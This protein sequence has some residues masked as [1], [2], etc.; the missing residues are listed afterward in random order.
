MIRFL[1]A[2]IA[3]SPHI[4]HAADPAETIDFLN[5]GFGDR[6]G[7][8]ANSVALNPALLTASLGTP[9]SQQLT[10]AGGS[11]SSYT[12]SI[13]SGGLPHGLTL[14]AS[15]LL[16]GT[17][18]SGGT[19]TFKVM[20]TDTTISGLIGERTYTMAIASSPQPYPSGLVSWWRAEGNTND[21][22]G[23][24]HATL[25]GSV[26]YAPGLVGQAF[27]FNGT[28]GYVALPDNLFPVPAT[29]STTQSPFSFEVWFKLAP[30]GGGV[31]LS[32]QVNS[33]YGTGGGYVPAIYIDTTGRL[34]VSMFWRNSTNTLGG[35]GPSFTESS[36]FHH[37][38]VTFN[39]TH[40]KIF[41][42]GVDTVP[43]PGVPFTQIAYTATYRYSLGTGNTA[44]GW[45][46]NNGGYFNFNGLIDEPSVYN[47]A[48]TL[49]EAQALFLAG[50]EGKSESQSLVVTSTSDVSDAK[51][52]QITLRE[53]F[54]YAATLSGTQT[55]TFS[56]ALAGQT[57]TLTSVS[58]NTFGPSAFAVSGSLI[59]DGGTGGITI[60]QNNPTSPTG[61][62][63]LFYVKNT[64]NLTLRN[65][66]LSGGL[67]RG[68]SGGAGGGA[69]GLGGAIVNAG[70][71]NISQSTLLGNEAR[72]GGNNLGFLLGGAGLGQNSS[73][74]G[75]GGPNGGTF[76][77]GGSGGFGGGAYSG[78]RTA[79]A[80]GFGGG[81]SFSQEA[82]AGRGGFG[83]GGGSS[84]SST[85]G[86]GGYGASGGDYYGGCGAGMGGAI[87]NYGGNVTLTNSTLVGN[88]AIG[89]SSLLFI[90]SGAAGGSAFGGGC[91]NL[92]GTVT[93]L[94][95]TAAN[96]IIRGGTGTSSG[97]QIGGAIYSLG[98]SDI[99]TQSGPAMSANAAN[100]VIQNSILSGSTNGVTT[101]PCSNFSQVA[102]GTGTV[103]SSGTH[104]CIQ[105]DGSTGISTFSGSSIHV[106]PLLAPLGNNGGPTQTFA[107]TL[108]SPAINAGNNAAATGVTTDQ[109][110]GSFARSVDDTVDIGA[111]ELVEPAS[112]VVTRADDVS[113]ANDFQTS[114]RE[115]ITYATTLSGT[116]TITFSNA[117]ADGA[118]NFHDGTARSITLTGSLLTVSTALNI[119]G[120]GANFLTLQ[121]T[122]GSTRVLNFSEFLPRTLTGLTISSP[123]LT[124]G[125]IS[126]TNGNLTLNQC[127]IT[128]NGIE[129]AS[130]GAG[131]SARG[132][133]LTLNGCTLT[134][135]SALRGGGVWAFSCDVT[136][137][138]CT[139]SGNTATSPTSGGGGLYIDQSTF[140]LN[141]CSL[142]GN[143]ASFN[144]GGIHIFG[145]SS[146]GTFTNCTLSG[147][148]ATI[149]G[150]GI[151]EV[152]GANITLN[153]C[154]LNGNR[155]TTGTG[156]GLNISA[157]ATTLRQ[158][159]IS[160]NAANSN[161]GGA[162]FT[163]SS[164]VNLSQCTIS[165]NTTTN[166][167]GGGIGVAGGTNFSISNCILGNSNGY[168]LSF[169]ASSP[170]YSGINL[171]EDG[172][173]NG[174]GII[175][176]DPLLGPL[177]NN[178]GLTQTHALLA[179]SPA[180][181]AGINTA[182][183][184]LT[185]DQ[186]GI[187]FPRILNTTVDL[188]AIE[189]PAPSPLV[190][191][192]NLH[193]L[194][195]NGSQDLGNPSGDGVSSLLKYAFNLA[196][197]AGSL[198]QPNIAILPSSGDAG[199][200]HISRTPSGQLQITYLR[201]KASTYPGITYTP[202]TGS[203]LS[204]FAALTAT[205]TVTSIDTNWERVTITDSSTASKRFGRVKVTTP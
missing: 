43:D 150:G 82:A 131:I 19:S 182:A 47:R 205:E 8:Q 84:I 101:A 41:L 179:G 28:N 9:F 192:R 124:S 132:G 95:V 194:A 160:G 89:G 144:G 61:G 189:A 100:V 173:A 109:R 63:R 115:A 21:T 203:I 146:V 5:A 79:Y 3:L 170:N 200:P 118:V 180:I 37:L 167:N 163:S 181:N 23:T 129:N 2:L 108:S 154:T 64:G 152:S 106:D 38:I 56:P 201:R 147:N 140:S 96:Q 156:G 158:C 142:S 53:A 183:G 32:Q 117:A 159:T 157:A 48:L 50:N 70:T 58:D 92:N 161:G 83:A 17:P 31:I 119:T 107:L 15:G 68:G 65:L 102:V 141:R 18:S 112:L 60:S 98:M 204:D 67:A 11:A 202:E 164:T 130:A 122:T 25:N 198:N 34:R 120:P 77:N 171:V 49:A 6:V 40:E 35:F 113:D 175:N 20:L 168:D 187:G 186:R 76:A 178:G 191:W 78:G 99:A 128:N 138:D 190:D 133:S 97:S 44:G 148:T 52:F 174:F 162:F 51:D 24:N 1:A 197:L 54:A 22:I 125:G 90:N 7:L 29:G 30:G 81:G 123:G 13:V 134:N 91:F 42:D 145:N 45:S 193:G 46:N 185:T 26:T 155:A 153:D 172:S 169:V 135:N 105:S 165:G 188:G 72:G 149:N 10:L 139:I 126:L 110:G 33:P 127:V 74:N 196:P 71:L 36:R 114:L 137:N 103:V 166:V 116:Q 14:S 69:A 93:L 143:V 59:I 66:T 85:S 4:I 12:A 195:L 87:F 73:Q 94:H 16:S 86:A 57:V 176:G 39:G 55:I 136:L 199:L 75:G 80:G 111:F 151:Y 184:D 88:A 104:N 62:M 177:A 121:R 27:S